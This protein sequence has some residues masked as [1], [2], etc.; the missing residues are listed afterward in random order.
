[1]IKFGFS[2]LYY[3]VKIREVNFKFYLLVFLCL[4][5]GFSLFKSIAKVG[6]AQKRIEAAKTKVESLRQVQATL[7]TELKKVQSDAFLEKQLRDKLGLAKKGETVVFLPDKEAL[8]GLVPP[9]PE[10]ENILPKPIRQRWLDL[11]K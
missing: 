10:E 4:L 9:L 5:F 11:F 2:V 6:E 8:K 7:E 1:M 3:M